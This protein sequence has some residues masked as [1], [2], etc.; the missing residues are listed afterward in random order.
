V[1]PIRSL[2]ELS[3]H[4]DLGRISHAPARF[5]AAELQ[6][7]SARTLHETSFESVEGRLAALGVEGEQAAPFWLAVRGNLT[8][9]ADAQD[10]WQ[11]INGP[12]EPLLED[13]QFLDAAAD[14]LPDEPWDQ[15]VWSAWTSA[16][17]RA[18]GRKGRELFHPLRL[19]LT[20]R[21]QGPELAVLLPLIG[22]VRARD[23]LRGLSA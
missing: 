7:L 12:V 4:F 5:D 16:V 22:R 17:K 3:A 10:W 19:A 2:E 21:E 13:R 11:V 14:V 8:K 20:A 23:R 6:A 15:G 1:R 9:L 18:T